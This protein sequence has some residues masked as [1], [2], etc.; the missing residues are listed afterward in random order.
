MQSETTSP[1]TSAT[2]IHALAHT[3]AAMPAAEW[4]RLLPAHR[5]P[6]IAKTPFM[7]ALGVYISG[8]RFDNPTVGK[9]MLLG[10]A[11]WAVLYALNEATDLTLEQHLHV[12]LLA[13][14]T[15]YAL[16]AA[17]C[18]CAAWLS[19]TLGLLFGMMAVGQL[20][21]CVPPLR[22]KRHWWAVLLLSG[23]A[24][25]VLRLECGALWGTHAVPLLAYIAFVSLHVG[26]SIRSR[27]LLRDRDRN[28]GYRIAPPRMEWAGMAC[29]SVGIIAAYGVCWQ[30]IVPPVFAVF[31]TA[32]AAFA[33]YAWS[34]RAAS[35]AQLRQGWLW[36][37]LLALIA[38]IVLYLHRA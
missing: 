2:E 20:A 5:L 4:R 35:V 1:L 22:L 28:F 24:N 10:G 16:C 8:G 14:Q 17:L 12:P 32:A 29:T 3:P 36:F 23:M 18:L 33:L 37:A 27:V 13:R 21:Y 19:P 15:L 30:G 11:L 26:A 31:T 9:T 7:I 25:P 34:G 38:C 6:V